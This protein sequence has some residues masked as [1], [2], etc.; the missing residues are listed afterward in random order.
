MTRRVLCSGVLLIALTFAAPAEASRAP[1]K[2]EAK[3]IKKG[4]LK[5]RSAKATTIRRMRVST[6]RAGWA[7]VSYTVEAR[8][9]KKLKAPTPVVL[10]KSGS[11]WKDV[12]PGKAPKKVKSDLKVPPATSNVKLTGEV[13]TVFKRAARCND[14]GVSIY[15][16]G[17]DLLLSIQQS[18]EEGDG[19]RPARGVRT[20][21]AVYRNKGTE[22]AYESG[23]PADAFAPS[24][25]FERD[26]DGWGRV[27]ADLAPPPVPEI[28]PFAVRVDG[29]W[30]CG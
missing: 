7:A 27:V 12:P 19:Y 22:L 21:V 30:V 15:D 28:R 18:R 17:A 23:A 2:A 9:A 16:P 24:G 25:F 4:F 3:A 8:T 5:G 1:T 29:I 14:S 10:K 13:S 11:K 26:P 6:A 20:V